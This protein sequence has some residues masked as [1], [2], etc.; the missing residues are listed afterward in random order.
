VQQIDAF[1]RFHQRYLAEKNATAVGNRRLH[2]FI[3]SLPEAERMIPGRGT[4]ASRLYSN[5]RADYNT[6]CRMIKNARIRGLIPFSSVIDEKNDPAIYMPAR[7]N[8]SGWI[9]PVLPDI[10]SLPDLQTVYEMPEWPEFVEAIEFRP[11]VE[12]APRF[13]YQP[14][15]MVIAIEKATSRERLEALARRYG[16]D[17]LIFSGQSSLTRI[18][19]V[20]ERAR[21][22]DKALAV[23]YV[24]DL[25]VAGWNMSTAFMTNVNAIYP[26]GDHVCESVALTRDQAVRYE[27]PTSF[28][29]ESKGYSEAEKARFI[30]ESGGRSCIELDALDESVLLDLLDKALSRHSYLAEDRAAEREARR[31]LQDDADELTGTVDLSRFRTEYEE[32]QAE[33]SQLADEV[34]TFRDDIGERVATVERWRK[35][36]IGRIFSDLCVSCGVEV[37]DE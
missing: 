10:G 7:S 29:P 28:D 34:R 12:K 24:S 35:H 23:L 27:L 20:C 8:F 9:E 33:H 4:G 19:D 31:R 22:E 11:F 26:R 21:A 1:V 6:L 5:S 13:A 37:V 2:Y 18:N 16:A 15:R 17:L 36:L 14:R 30:A 32:M 3:V 25:D